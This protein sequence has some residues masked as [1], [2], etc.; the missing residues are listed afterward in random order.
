MNQASA[1]TAATGDGLVVILG[2]PGANA[3]DVSIDGA[4][5]QVAPDLGDAGSEWLFY[6]NVGIESD[7]DRT[8]T[9]SFP[10]EV[11]GPWGPAVSH[12]RREWTWLGTET[13]DRIEFTHQF[14]AGERAFFAF[15]FP[16]VL[17]D[18]ERFWDGL[19]GVAG[20]ERDVLTRTEQGRAVP[21]VRVG[22]PAADSHAVFTCR[23]HACES[24]ASFVLEGVLSTLADR[25]PD[26][27]CAHVVPFVDLDGVQQGDQG[28]ERLPHDHNRDYASANGV[29]D[30]IDPLYATT[31]ALQSYVSSLDGDCLLGLDLHS[32]FK[33]GEPHDR[34]FFPHEPS[35]VGERDRQ[36]ARLLES[37]TDRV[38][39]AF[40]F[41]ESDGFQSILGRG[42]GTTFT[43]FLD[44]AGFDVSLGLEVPY[45]GTEND[46][47]T[48]ER[49]RGLGRAI[50]RTA[51]EVVDESLVD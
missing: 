4:S 1:V 23:H 37:Q 34:A 47:V 45:F 38:E 46:R 9:V 2:Y 3:T 48:P 25:Q 36:F 8:V 19:D 11:V 18:F 7:D 32:P 49:C 39:G 43:A 44:R 26:D 17:A 5:V 6:W 16:Y 27:W 29:L 10:D 35:A 24:P 41:S 14:S 31:A 28:K 50:G 33:W 21:L 42:A 22:N 20:V 15:S 30:D 51:S 13:D 12:D 40:P